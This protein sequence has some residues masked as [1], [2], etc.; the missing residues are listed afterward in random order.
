MGAEA[1]TP[2]YPLGAPLSQANEGEEESPEA[3]AAGACLERVGMGGHERTP[4]GK[5]SKGMTQRV[6][7]A[8][9]LVGDPRLLIL[10]EPASG[11]DPIGHR[12][13][14][15]ILRELAAEGRTIF[16]SS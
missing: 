3:K 9:A 15:T 11:L 2:G 5:L 10:D 16:L 12:D 14:I 1:L 7:L 6:A 4:L 13:M 8:A